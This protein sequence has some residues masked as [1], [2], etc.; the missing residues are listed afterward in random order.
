MAVMGVAPDREAVAE[1]A[2]HHHAQGQ[3]GSAFRWSIALNSGLTTL[4]LALGF[5]LIGDA[6]HNL[7][8]VVGLALGW[9]CR[10]TA[11]GLLNPPSPCGRRS[12]ASG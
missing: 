6:L 12:P 4:H 11:V 8:G 2:D 7:G 10:D 5:G 9:G 3:A 1:G